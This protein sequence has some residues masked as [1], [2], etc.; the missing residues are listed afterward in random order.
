MKNRIVL[1]VMAVF[2]LTI[3][4]AV[5]AHAQAYTESTF[6][7]FPLPPVGGMW[8]WGGLITDGAGNFY[9]TTYAGGSPICS[10]G[11]GTVFKLDSSGVET[12]LHVFTGDDGENPQQTLTLDAAGNLYSTI[13]GVGPAADG[14][15]FKIDAAGTFSIVHTFGGT[16]GKIPYG[17]V[18]LDAAGN[19]YGTTTLGGSNG[20]GVVFKIDTTGT[21]TVMYDFLGTTDGDSPNGNL[22][23]D[24]LGNVYGT[25]AGGGFNGPRGGV[26]F[27][28]TPRRVEM[29]L[30]SFCEFA[31]CTDGGQPSSLVRVGQ[32]MFGVAAGGTTGQGVIFQ[33]KGSGVGTVLHDFCS[34]GVASG[35]KDGASPFGQLL[36][37]GG[38]LY[39]T[40]S[41]GGLGDAGVVY[42]LNPTSGVETG[43]YRFPASFVGGG[44]PEG[45]VVMDSAGN[46]YGAAYSGGRQGSGLIFKL[47]KN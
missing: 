6:Y 25:A 22:V 35:C 45:G 24:S 40:T 1:L 7:A 17:P 47:T 29:V 30:H 18:T 20:H 12:V 21:E 16:D 44:N 11:C 34:A 14:I 32:E 33:I 23:L 2:A 42:E 15:V 39:G 8:P 9:G 31:G 3:T 36:V 10:G 43:I 41:A 13:V 46:I 19:I 26:V 5:S 27:K 4:Y 28:V 38:N 37:S